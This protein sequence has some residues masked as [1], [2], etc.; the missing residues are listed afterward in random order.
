[1][2]FEVEF[3]DEEIK[4]FLREMSRKMNQVKYGQSQYV[5]LIS[6][7]VYRDV[8]EH[9]AEEMGPEGKWENWSKSYLQA[10]A[11]LVY[12][13]MVNGRPKAFSTENMKSPPKPPRKPGLKLQATGRLRNSFKPRNVRTGGEG[14][15]WFNNA[16]TAD[17]VSYA[18]VHNYGAELPFGEI[19]AR[20]Y[21]W[22]SNKGFEDILTET[23]Q[24]MAEKDV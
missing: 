1:M 10:I 24:F 9:F 16:K 17:G 6:A 11:G 7:I 3:Q 15:L 13:R 18:A 4:D 19:P 20:P 22:L 2:A 5:A 14:I 23:L 12:F 8:M 21:M